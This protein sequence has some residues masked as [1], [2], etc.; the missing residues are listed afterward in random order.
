VLSPFA[1]IMRRPD[2][3]TRREHEPLTLCA[4]CHSRRSSSRYVRSPSAVLAAIG[5]NGASAAEISDVTGLPERTL[6]R[7]L[8]RLV[9]EGVLERRGRSRSTRYFLDAA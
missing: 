1:T 3:P 9:A 4:P 7:H 6:R 8:A 5:P 2:W